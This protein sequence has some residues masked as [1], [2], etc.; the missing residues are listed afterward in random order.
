MKSNYN[1]AIKQFNDGKIN[2]AKEICTE[3][4]KSEPN[5]FNAYYLLGVILFQTKNYVKSNE[6]ISK[7]IEINP[8][9]SEFYNFKG[10]AL[11]HINKFEEAIESWTKAI[12][13]DPNRIQRRIETRYLDCSTDSLDDALKIAKKSLK[14]N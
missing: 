8:K 7:A 5:N 13:I 3:I 6:L 9:N 11:I 1:D 10:I 14:K 12:E 4:L 2:E